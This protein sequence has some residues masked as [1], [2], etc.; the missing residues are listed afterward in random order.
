[1]SA[2]DYAWVHGIFDVAKNFNTELLH[3][4][5]EDC[6]KSCKPELYEHIIEKYIDGRPEHEW[7]TKGFDPERVEA[8]KQYYRDRY[9]QEVN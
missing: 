1:M 2:P 8:I 6:E 4:V 7:F 5:E 3:H 9:N